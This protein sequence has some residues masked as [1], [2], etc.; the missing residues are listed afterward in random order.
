[1][2]KRGH[3]IING[4]P[5]IIVNQIIRAS[6]I[7]YQQ[8]VHKSFQQS[9][10]YIYR[11]FFVDIISKRGVWIRFEMDKKRKIW[12]CMKKTPKIPLFLFLYSLGFT[13]N[14]IFKHLNN[15]EQ[16]YLM[17][18]YNFY[19]SNSN[20]KFREELKN[21]NINLICRN[22]LNPHIYDLGKIG[23]KRLNLKLGLNTNKTTLTPIDFLKLSYLLFSC[24]QNSTIIDDIDDLRNRRIRS[25]GELLEIQFQESIL[26]M[27]TLFDE[28]MKKAKKSTNLW[29]N[30]KPLNS[31]LKEFFASC[32]LSQFLDQTNPL[33]ELTHKRRISALGP[34]GI[35]RET[36]GMEIR[37]IHSTYF[38][39][40]CPIETPEGQ[41]AGLV[42]SLTVFTRANYNGFLESA[43]SKVY[44][45]QIQKNTIP[46]Y[47]SVELEQ[48]WRICFPD[49]RLS[50]LDFLKPKSLSSRYN[51]QLMRMHKQH[52]QLAYYSCFQFISLATSLIPFLEHNDANRVLMGSNMQRQAVPLLVLHPAQISG[53]LEHKVLHIV[54]KRLIRVLF[55]ML[56]KIIL[57]C[58][59]HL[60]I[61][62]FPILRFDA[63]AFQ[64]L[65]SPLFCI[66]FEC[67]LILFLIYTCL[68][69]HLE[70]E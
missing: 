69:S 50:S 13:N 7:Y 59:Y 15:L 9:Q 28:K 67:K 5:R 32:Q 20:F 55:Y 14:L 11:T 60:Q 38:G 12:V 57:I 29:L 61:P 19:N 62:H 58:I 52:M 47:R 70:K 37:G 23:R 46:Q 30:T 2:T 27:E 21:L 66:L 64:H 39:R 34:N 49:I 17:Y 33:A 54:F 22:F 44:K 26:R 35:Q 40:V 48:Q 6:G 36:A 3:F 25:I 68:G 51:L 43:F 24:T 18:K 63:C 53:F 45:S 16:K 10:K 4:I 41:N 8:K 1:M 56:I 31:A 65:D 42:N